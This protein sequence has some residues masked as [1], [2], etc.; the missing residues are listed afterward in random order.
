MGI[1]IGTSIS[2]GVVGGTNPLGSGGFSWGTA[3]GE[4]KDFFS[5]AAGA[6][7]AY[8]QIKRGGDFS[9][10]NQDQVY[11]TPTTTSPAPN[12]PQGVPVYTVGGVPVTYLAV[13]GLLLVGAVLVAKS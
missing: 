10:A 2:D 6:W 1:P 5:Q 13:G 12:P 3:L 8:E 9:G 7:L 11:Q 4:T